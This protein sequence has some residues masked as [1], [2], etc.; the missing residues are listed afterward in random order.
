MIGA[1]ADVAVVG[2]GPAGVAAALT[3]AQAGRHVVLV[4]KATFPR[5]K[6]CGDGVTT[7][8]WRRY[9]ALGLRPDAVASWQPVADAVLCSPA[10]RAH[11]L[12]LPRTAI[13]RRTDLDAA[14]VDVARAAGVKVHD[15]HALTGARVASDGVTVDV[16]GVGSMAAPYV[17]AADGMWSTVRKALEVNPSPASYLGHWHAFRQYFHHVGPD[18][19][20]RM[21]VWFEPDVLPGYA[22]SFPLPDGRANVGFGIRRGVEPTGAMKD[23]WPDLLGRAHIAAVLGPD[24]A[25]EAP[26]KAWPIPCG[27]DTGVLAAAGGRVLFAG[28]AARLADPMT[29]EGIGQALESG[30]EAARAILRAGPTD[31]GGAARRYAAAIERGLALDNRLAAVLSGVLASPVW[32]E[33]VLRLAGLTTWTRRNFSRWL[34]EAYPRAV[35]G[36][37]WRWASDHV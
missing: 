16:E 24:A 7:G 33:R 26:H 22:W 9:E 11:E 1:T 32:A 23:L 18:A 31:P 19:R 27:S 35:V 5:D 36:T 21:W 34:L 30:V 4:D 17:V 8:A 15:G 13:A 3:L 2:G 20:E 12:P 6:C 25:P 37:P 14:F 29:G 28:D 10:G